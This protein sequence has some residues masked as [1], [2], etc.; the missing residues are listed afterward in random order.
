MYIPVDAILLA[1]FAYALFQGSDKEIGERFKMIFA[2]I[3]L[4][5]M[6]AAI[7]FILGGLVYMMVERPTM[8]EWLNKVCMVIGLVPVLSFIPVMIWARIKRKATSDGVSKDKV[9][10]FCSTKMTHCH[11]CYSQCGID[12]DFCEN[13]GVARK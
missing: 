2:G 6:M 7:V 13:C 12:V 11:Q 5:A 10:S 9:T 4:L 3:C 8:P 1:M